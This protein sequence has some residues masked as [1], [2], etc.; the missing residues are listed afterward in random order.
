MTTDIPSLYESFGLYGSGVTL[1]TVRDGDDDRFFIAASVLTSSVDPF[2][3]AISVGRDREALP[4]IVDG[5]T[6]AVSVLAEP[7]VPLVRRLTARTTR[8]ERLDALSAAGAERSPEG[9]LWL[10]DALV[11][12]WCTTHSTTPVNDQVLLVGQVARGSGHAESA[13]LVRWNREFRTVAA[14][15][16]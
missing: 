3:L 11:T 9:P 14:L 16:A 2:T 10:P 6:W 15:S 4:A 7:H 1:V 12:L 5:A 8:D 13:P